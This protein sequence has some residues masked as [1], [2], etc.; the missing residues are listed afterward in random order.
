MFAKIFSTTCFHCGHHKNNKHIKGYKNLKDERQKLDEKM[1]EQPW[2]RINQFRK[3]YFTK[4]QLWGNVREKHSVEIQ[5]DESLKT[6]DHF[7]D[8][9]ERQCFVCFQ[10]TNG[11]K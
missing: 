9:I 2:T 10:E 7:I 6:C 3:E 1:S 5:S 11:K 4:E 8:N